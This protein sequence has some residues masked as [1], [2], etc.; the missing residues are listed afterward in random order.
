L[1]QTLWA[2]EDTELVESNHKY[3]LPDP[4]LRGDKLREDKLRGHKLQPHYSEITLRYLTGQA[5]YTD[6]I[7]AKN[8]ENAE[9]I[10][11]TSKK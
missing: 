8:A 9:K 7:D 5:D 6:F 3:P 1:T 2:T 11:F 10:Q 4:R